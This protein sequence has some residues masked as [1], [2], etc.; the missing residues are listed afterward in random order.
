M[1]LTDVVR[2]TVGFVLEE[3]IDATNSTAMPLRTVLDALVDAL[4]GIGANAATIVDEA[5][6][7]LDPGLLTPLTQL[8]IRLDEHKAT[9]RVVYGSRDI[10]LDASAVA[11][12]RHRL[13]NMDIADDLFKST[14]ADFSRQLT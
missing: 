14:D 4:A 7:A 5:A 9:L 6:A 11:L 8:F 2:G 1:L 3:A 13:Q 12:A 10:F